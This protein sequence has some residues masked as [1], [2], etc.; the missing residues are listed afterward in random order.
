MFSRLALPRAACQ[1]V[2]GSWLL[3]TVVSCD[4]APPTS[5]VP[6][7]ELFQ[8]SV[9]YPYW[10]KNWDN[11]ADLK[12]HFKGPGVTK[13]IILVRHGQYD[14]SS[15]EDE[16]NILTELGRQQAEATGQRLAALLHKHP[17]SVLHVSS[18]AR[19]KETAAIIAKHLPDAQRTEPDPL[20]EEGRFAHSIPT[21]KYDPKRNRDHPRIEQAFAKYFQ[22]VVDSPSENQTHEYEVIVCHG[23]VIRYLTCRA[24]QIPPEAWLRMCTMNCSLTYL[25][26]RPSGKVSVR[27]LGDVGHLRPEEI[28]FSKHHGFDW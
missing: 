11:K 14:E 17:D 25:V 27:T 15:P 8:P 4:E 13:H 19:A 26:I 28:T 20:L 10:D 3:R 18:M 16:K 12:K 5:H 24:L 7:S 23:N 21:R 9:P 1:C 2:A 22:R 6:E